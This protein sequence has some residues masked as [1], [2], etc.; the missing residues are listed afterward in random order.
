MKSLE[1]QL[2]ERDKEI[3]KLKKQMAGKTNVQESKTTKVPLNEAFQDID[4]HF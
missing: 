3:A 4:K 2:C 1:Q